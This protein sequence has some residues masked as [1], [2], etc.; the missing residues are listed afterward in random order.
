MEADI[1]RARFTTLVVGIAA[2]W[3]LSRGASDFGLPGPEKV[4]QA[5]LSLLADGRLANALQVT[6]SSFA[7]G[8]LVSLL[9]GVPLGILMGVRPWFGR[10]VDPF[11]TG[12]YVMPMTAAV[13]LFVLWFGVDELVRM[14]FIF[15]FTVPQVAMVCYQGARTEPASLVEVAKTHMGSGRQIFW[16]VILPYQVPFIFTSLRLGVGLAIEGM[17]VAELL[18]TSVNGVGYL[19][20][21]ASASLDLATVIALVLFIMML[22]IGAVAVMQRL[23]NSVAPWREGMPSGRRS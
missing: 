6:L 14:V 5:L 23:E 16:K 10:A 18:I 4:G 17:V 21:T 15:I 20:Q 2:W 9:V 7:I 3:L 1:M 19:L 12:L 11:L 13:P 22:G 8:G